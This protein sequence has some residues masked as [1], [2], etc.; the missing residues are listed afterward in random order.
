MDIVNSYNWLINI[1][2]ISTLIKIKI[3]TTT[4]LDEL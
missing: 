3:E 1:I 2:H 4:L